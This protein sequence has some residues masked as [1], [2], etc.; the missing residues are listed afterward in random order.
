M[1]RLLSAV[2]GRIGIASVARCG[3][4]LS[5]QEHD[6]DGEPRADIKAAGKSRKEAMSAG[7][8]AQQSLE[9][10]GLPPMPKR[11]E[12]AITMEDIL[13]IGNEAMQEAVEK[14]RRE[15]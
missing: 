3:M 5:M 4:L 15:S 9:A 14:L 7:L 12:D 8:L 1:A 2:V 10:D 11:D 6:S 13:R